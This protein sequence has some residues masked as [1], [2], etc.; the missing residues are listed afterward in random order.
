MSI[1]YTYLIG[2]SAHNKWY[3]GVR[4]A[5]TCHPSDLFKTYFTSSKYVKLFI[6]SNGLPDIIEIRRTFS[7]A[8]DAQKWEHTVLNRTDAMHDEKFL[9]RSNNKSVLPEDA[10][11]GAK[12]SKPMKPNDIRRAISREMMKRIHKIYGAQYQTPEKIKI[13]FLKSVETRKERMKTHGNT[14]GELSGYIKLKQYTKDN[15]YSN[16]GWVDRNKGLEM[17]SRNNSEAECP[18]CKSI[19]QYRAMKRWHFDNCESIAGSGKGTQAF[20]DKEQLRQ[21]SI[22]RRIKVY[23][24]GEI[25]DS[26][27]AAGKQHNITAA[28]VNGRCKS[29]NYPDWYFA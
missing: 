6:I 24:D 12:T 26:Q 23:A 15:N 29:D 7:N 5:K 19:G 1:P 14:D 3:Y 13:V 17:S 28:S 8:R 20:K 2:W 11:R 18:H 16:D 25:Y 10:L 9:N 27:T 4:Y 21:F 22:P